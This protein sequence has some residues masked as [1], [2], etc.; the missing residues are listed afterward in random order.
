MKDYIY[1]GSF[2]GL[3]TAIFYAYPAKEHINIVKEIN[4]IPSLLNTTKTIDTEIDKFTRVYTS[5]NEK[6]NLSVLE[7]IYLVYLSDIKGAEN[8]ILDYLRLCYKYGIKINLAKNNDTIIL[9]DRYSKKVTNEA[10]LLTGFIRFKEISPARYYSSIEPE[11]NILPLIEKHFTKRFSDQCFI[12]HDIK[13]SLA[14]VYNG[15]S[16]II[17]H[18]DYDNYKQINNNYDIEYSKLWKTFYN[19]VNIEER[20]NIRCMKQHMPRKYWGHMN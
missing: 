1:D 2:E 5:I 20:R 14:I 13:R 19:S 4:F 11:Y 10:H 16:S 6:L 15:N 8:V 7:N 18:F 12:I 17:T 9:I 3:L